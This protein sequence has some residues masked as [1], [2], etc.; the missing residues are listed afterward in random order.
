[1]YCPQLVCYTVNIKQVLPTAKSKL[2][3]PQQFALRPRVLT[4]EQEDQIQS[5]GISQ[6][7]SRE[8]KS[9]EF[10]GLKSKHDYQL[11]TTYKIIY[12]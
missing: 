7:G 8:R 12:R 9:Q 5:T 11:N 6:K 2:L 4:R 10:K 1:M 3:L